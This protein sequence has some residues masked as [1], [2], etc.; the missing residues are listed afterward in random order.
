MKLW[1]TAQCC[2]WWPCSFPKGWCLCVRCYAKSFYDAG[3][4][5]PSRDHMSSPRKWDFIKKLMNFSANI[6]RTLQQ[7][8]F[9]CLPVAINRS[10]LC[11]KPLLLSL[12]Y[13][14]FFLTQSQIYQQR[15]K[16]RGK[17]WHLS[18]FNVILIK[19]YY[20]MNLL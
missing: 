12:N 10:T 1:Y 18:D 8:Y 7:I 4:H 11:A 20:W 3:S 17:G 15:E 6:C 14:I 5:E 9:F 16:K 13:N 2:W 19:N